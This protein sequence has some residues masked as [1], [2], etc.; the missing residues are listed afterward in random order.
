MPNHS[1][2]IFCMNKIFL[3][4]GSRVQI[5]FSSAKICAKIYA[6]VILKLDSTFW[7]CLATGGKLWETRTGYNTALS[8]YL[9]EA[10]R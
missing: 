10:Y 4:Y 3:N 6:K 2:S 1:D 7:G 5:Y 9:K 8:L